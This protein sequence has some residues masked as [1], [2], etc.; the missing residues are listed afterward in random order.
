VIRNFIYLD[1]GKLRSLSSQLFE[2][3]TEQVLSTHSDT[4]AESESQKGPVA[5]G[6]LL[7]E[8]FS[9]ESSSSELKFLEDHAYTL[10]EERLSKSELIQNFDSVTPFSN[11]EKKF[12]KVTS[13]LKIND[14]ALSATVM[15]NFN[16]VGEALWRVTNEGQDKSAS[17]KNLSDADVKKKAREAGLQMN[18][19]YLESSAILLD[20]GFQDLLEANFSIQGGMFSAPLKREFLRE[21]ES[22]IVHKY[23]RYTQADFTIVGLITQHGMI[24]DAGPPLSQIEGSQGM[25]QAMRVLADYVRNMEN[26]FSA[27]LSNE[28][29]LDPIAIYSVI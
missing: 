22:M 26:T 18:Q 25:K 6:K 29:I 5:S 7:G 10:L 14:L 20:F 9:K 13:K 16:R 27:P 11:T 17:V 23:S 3:V 24:P 21:S 12:V 19:K 15:K 1:S 28:A 2:G 8:I 4:Q